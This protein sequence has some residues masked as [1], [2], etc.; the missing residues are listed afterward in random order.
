LQS[1]DQNAKL[2]S[3]KGKVAAIPIASEEI[4]LQE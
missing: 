4:K 1:K 2:L 3:V